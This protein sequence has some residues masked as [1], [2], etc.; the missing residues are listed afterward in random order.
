MIFKSR[1]TKK[2]EKNLIS[3]FGKK[4][5]LNYKI[6]EILLNRGIDDSNIDK[7]LNSNLSD[8]KDPFLL[9]GMNECVSRIK[10]AIDK[11]QNVL[12][13]GDYDVDGISATA[14]IYKFLENKISKVNYFL[15][16]RYIDGYG[17]TIDSAKKVIDL[18]QP[19]LIITV[20]C[21]ISCAKEVEYI[22]SRGVDIIITDHHEV[23][24]EIPQTIVV[25]AKRKDETYGFD[26]LCGTGVALKVVQAFVGV[27][28]LEEYLPIC[29]IATVSDIVP[30]VDENRAIVKLGL[31]RQKLLPE[32]IKMLVKSMKIN[33]INS[34]AISFKIAPKLNAAG[35]MGNANPALNLYISKNK[36]EI[37]KCLKA[38]DFQNTKRQSIS[39]QIY[40]DCLA[41]IKENRLFENNSIILKNKNWDSGLLG[42]ACARLV[43]DFYRPVFLF[44]EVDGELKGSV[45][46]IDGINIHQVLSC[47]DEIL[48]TYGGHSMAAGLSL[49]IEN[50]EIFRE[51][52][53]EYLERN[54]SKEN[55]LPVKYYDL[56]INADDITTEFAKELLILEPF[57]CENPNPLFLIEYKDC[58][59]SKLSGH[60]NHLNLV[61]DK[62][63]K[64]IAFNSGDYF[65]DYLYSTK[66]QT[67]L[68]IQLNTFGKTTSAKGIVKST[69]F[70]GYSDKLQ[71][72]ANG[73]QLKQLYANKS[74]S[75]AIKFFDVNKL[76][77]LL[78][79]L[80]KHENGVA[81]I[82]NN[83]Q[84]YLDLQNI[85]EKYE[86][87]YYVGGS[88]SKFAENCVIFALDGVESLTNYK[89]TIFVDGLFDKDFLA[90]FA[91]QVYCAN[92]TVF[93]VENL[94]FERQT[95]GNLFIA[96]KNL[97]NSKNVYKNELDFYEGLKRFNGGFGKL[98]YSQFVLCFYTFLQLDIIKI[99]DKEEFKLEIDHSKKTNLENSSFYNKLKFL[100][101]IK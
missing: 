65:D 49:K 86:L 96:I 80:L 73:R 72:I 56:Q 14:I 8:L 46:S 101:K 23:P 57:G 92:N 32:G 34:T 62:K 12:I 7:F 74:Y 85:F 87:N 36:N 94:D 42:I 35:R 17:L 38:L 53:I 95:F 54:K 58:N 67:I 98:S 83:K 91:G 3:E 81:I 40:E 70:Y 25:D 66:K 55:Y 37:N 26:G 63:V 99:V 19:D 33:D 93:R 2:I 71:N 10:E 22:K 5:N 100:S 29:A 84:T 9:K 43:D 50:F 18:Y 41:E 48:D 69:L 52:I 11:N 30:L 27:E 1:Q 90:D 20:D 77:E 59:A 51:R 4:H 15:P 6:A 24:D 64:A 21:G 16:N 68:E 31:E 13:F 79:N 45:R 82:V 47:C 75:N 61:F 78:N 88:Q 39:Q 76:D 44:S 60:D 89:Y 97:I 28:N